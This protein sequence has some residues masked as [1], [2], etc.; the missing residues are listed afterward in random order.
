[1]AGE[2]NLKSQLQELTKTLAIDDRV[3][4]LGQV[5]H[6]QLLARLQ[7]R[8]PAIVVLPSVDLGDGV[9]EG[10]PVALVEA[11]SQGIPAI[12]TST[13]G[14]PELLRGGAGLIVPPKDS[15]ALADAIEQVLGDAQL[16]KR[17]AEAGRRRVQEE[18]AIE[19]VTDKFIEYVENAGR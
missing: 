11:M 4:F 14:I 9:H 18:F 16:Q 8:P 2:G 10:I 13:G 5:P 17:L 6:E 15:Q 1:V 7:K 3:K 19:A 12:S